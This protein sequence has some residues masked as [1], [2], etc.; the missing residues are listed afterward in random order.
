VK[1]CQANN[2]AIFQD[3]ERGFERRES[4]SFSGSH[5]F[6]AGTSITD[7]QTANGYSGTKVKRPK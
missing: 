7:F 2:H 3:Q 1:F 5:V 4:T 6:A